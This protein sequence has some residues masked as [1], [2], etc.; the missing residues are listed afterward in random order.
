MYIY[1]YIYIYM[2]TY[3][4]IYICICI[5]IHIRSGEP[6]RIPSGILGQ[7]TAA[8]LRG[9]RRVS[10]GVFSIGLAGW[11]SKIKSN[12]C[13]AVRCSLCCSVLQCAAVCCVVLQCVA[14]CCSV[15]VQAHSPLGSQDAKVI[16]CAAAC[17]SAYRIVLHCATLCCSGCCSV[18][19][20]LQRVS[21]G[22]FS[23]GLAGWQV[24]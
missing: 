3:I 9:K 1:T 15:L 16:E 21:A 8:I 13:V 5:Y 6:S 4:Y 22:V 7:T 11:Q 24:K 20:M 2:Y 23:S 18:C 14:V 17:C 19:S 12:K 10:A